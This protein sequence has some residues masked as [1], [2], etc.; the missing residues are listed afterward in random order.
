[1]K[2]IIQGAVWGSLSCTLTMDQLSKLSYINPEELLKYKGVRIPPLDMVDN[3][4]TVTNLGKNIRK[5]PV[6]QQIHRKQNIQTI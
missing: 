2:K 3:I 4:L 6:S 1:M 5:K